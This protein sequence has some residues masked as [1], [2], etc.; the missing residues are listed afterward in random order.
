MAAVAQGSPVR[1]WRTGGWNLPPLRLLRLAE[2]QT[3]CPAAGATPSE[4]RDSNQQAE[5]V[6]LEHSKLHA[7]I[8][9]TRRFRSS[10][11]PYFR[12][13]SKKTATSS[14]GVAAPVEDP[15]FISS[16][17]FTLPQEI[18]GISNEQGNNGASGKH[19]S[20]KKLP[21]AGWSISAGTNVVTSLLILIR[22]QPANERYCRTGQRA[23]TSEK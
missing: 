5:P 16:S 12:C 9:E 19:P 18:A 4:P 17:Y 21:A 1:R 23:E 10:A 8:V 7:R 22:S 20:R 11:L 6:S 3:R 2:P 14:C 15:L 13:K